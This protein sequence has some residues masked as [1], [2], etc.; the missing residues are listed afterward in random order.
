MI[1]SIGRLNQ[2]DRAGFT[3]IELILTT[4]IILIIVGLST[5]LLRKTYYDLRVNLQAKDLTGLMNL[6]REKAIMTRVPH[7]VKLDVD[8]NTYRML[9]ADLKKDK[10]VPIEGKWGRRFHILSN[11]KIESSR[12]II[13]FFPDGSS[14]G[15]SVFFKDPSGTKSRIKVDA[16]TGEITVG[17]E[18]EK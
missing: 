13:K 7:A 3:F 15:V 18:Q 14:N 16:G 10:T 4:L 11:L 8:K 9:T 17:A 2:R 6:A 1:L 5:P 12:E